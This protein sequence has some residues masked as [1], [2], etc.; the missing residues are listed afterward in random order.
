MKYN[1]PEQRLTQLNGESDNT[2]KIPSMEEI[3]CSIAE[4]ETSAIK[5]T[6]SCGMY[7]SSYDFRLIDGKLEVID[8]G[9]NHDA[10]RL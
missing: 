2:F 3:R 8:I 5:R 4:A 7:I 1:S 6:K 10:E 9:K